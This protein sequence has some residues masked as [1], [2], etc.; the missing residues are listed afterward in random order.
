MVSPS[1]IETREDLQKFILTF[2]AL[3]IRITCLLA[4]APYVPS[5]GVH[6][7]TR[8]NL[9]QQWSALLG[10]HTFEPVVYHGVLLVGSSGGLCALR[11]VDGR[12]LWHVEAGNEIFTPVIANAVAYAGNRNGT[13]YAFDTINRLERW[14][15]RFPG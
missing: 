1:Q 4:A 3:S 10:E 5:D 11:T 15:A 8:N 14:R 12:V 6:S 7:Q 13:L 9:H 2:L